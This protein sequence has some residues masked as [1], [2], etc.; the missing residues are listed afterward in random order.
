MAKEIMR[1]TFLVIFYLISLPIV[2][3]W[4]LVY[5]V[6][7]GI[8]GITV[9]RYEF[10]RTAIRRDARATLKYRKW[11]AEKHKEASLRCIDDKTKRME[12]ETAYKEGRKKTPGV[13]GYTITNIIVFGIIFYPP[14]L[15]WGAV[16]GPVRAFIEFNKWIYKLWTGHSIYRG[17]W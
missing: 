16:T 15:I 1:K 6:I 5:G 10:V 11:Q 17:E 9:D 8:I 14:L 12:A 13:I 3:P 2:L 7:I 4:C